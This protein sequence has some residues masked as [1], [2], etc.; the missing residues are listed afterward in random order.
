VRSR[1][2]QQ[3][4]SPLPP[5][6][7]GWRRLGDYTFSLRSERPA[8]QLR[9]SGKD[10][11]LPRGIEEEQLIFFDTE[12]TGLSGAGTMVFLTGAGKIEGG[13]FVLRQFFL[14]DYPGE[15]EY[16]SILESE[17]P[18]DAYYVTYN[19]KAFDRNIL[20]GRF[21]L[22]G[23][24]KELQ[25]QID[26]LYPSRRLF[27][28]V[29]PSCSLGDIETGILGIRRSCDIPGIMVPGRYFD[30]LSSG[31]AGLLKEVF[32]HHGDDVYHL[33]LLLSYMEALFADP[34][35]DT[36]AD[37][38]ELARFLLFRGDADAEKLL[39]RLA[40]AG[41][42][43]ALRELGFLCKRR[44]DREAA[45][46]CWE[47]LFNAGDPAGGV[48]LAKYFE[49]S[50][51]NF[52]GALELVDRMLKRPLSREFRDELL[53]RRRRLEHKISSAERGSN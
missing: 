37:S 26:L 41:D 1:T 14:A 48:E 15:P 9:F 28:T 36:Q 44:G 27:R 45:R 25:R 29:L 42:R 11:L 43:R 35:A 38:F 22:N 50:E 52:S 10:V 53:Y 7:P 20:S 13:R 31:D 47:R 39:E 46:G 23:M 24:R 30:Y 8:G 51:K 2:A 5:D 6:L 12:T 3:R 4:K 16:L 17:L 34:L 18:E 40:S 19:G 32:S 49:H 33:Y 21:L